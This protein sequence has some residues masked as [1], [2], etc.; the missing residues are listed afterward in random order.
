[1]NIRVENHYKINFFKTD[2]K[3]QNYKQFPVEE[4]C[5]IVT[6]T[7]SRIGRSTIPAI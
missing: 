2:I 7:P 4:E 3:N 1:M 5:A 6:S